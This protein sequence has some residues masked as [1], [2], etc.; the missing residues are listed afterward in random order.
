MTAAP[1][2][3][4][5]PGGDDLTA[6]I[7]QALDPEFDLRAINGT[8]VVVPKGVRWFA[9]H[10][11]GNIARQISDHPGSAA[12]LAGPGQIAATTSSAESASAP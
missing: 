12:D 4:G 7:F 11:L 10:S 2:A 9:G 3:A 5:Q 8:Y 6:R 1:A